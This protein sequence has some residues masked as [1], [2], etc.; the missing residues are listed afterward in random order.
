MSRA[1]GQ[2]PE[3]E[4]TMHTFSALLLSVMA[5]TA[6]V[7]QAYTCSEIA[8]DNANPQIAKADLN[9]FDS[10]DQKLNAIKDMFLETFPQQIAEQSFKEFTAEKKVRNP[11]RA[12]LLI[13]KSMLQV[14]YATKSV[15]DEAIAKD[16]G[17][18]KF[19]SRRCLNPSN[20]VQGVLQEVFLIVQKE[21]GK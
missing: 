11:Y 16:G 17:I 2:N 18:S 4:I 5:I 15:L 10:I 13:Y 1:R 20:D 19:I 8:R 6:D 9:G 3:P 12:S 7:A 21:M 14:S